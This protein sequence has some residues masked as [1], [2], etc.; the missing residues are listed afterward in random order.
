MTMMMMMIYIYIQ[1]LTM[2]EVVLELE[3]RGR[4][5]AEL[6]E[7]VSSLKAGSKKSVSPVRPGALVIILIILIIP[8]LRLLS[9]TFGSADVSSMNPVSHLILVTLITL[10]IFG[11][12][13]ASGRSKGIYI[14][15]Y[16]F[17]RLLRLAGYLY[18]CIWV[19]S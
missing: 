15:I 16:R 5:I 8:N 19:M 3:T 10:G 7:E 1:A 11:G 6:E 18:G 2:S 14:Y 12:S 9:L 13:S 17:I 4:R